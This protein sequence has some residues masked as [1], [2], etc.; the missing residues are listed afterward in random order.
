M[1]RRSFGPR[2]SIASRWFSIGLLLVTIGS[3]SACSVP[4]SPDPEPQPGPGPTPPSTRTAADLIE[5]TN[6]ERA[7]TG[8]PALAMNGRLMEAAQIQ[9]E[10]VAAAGR[11]EHTIADARLPSLE[12][13][14]AAAGYDWQYVGENLAFGQRNAAHAVDT[15][16][17]SPSHRS[18]IL[19]AL[20]TEVGAGYVVDPTGRPYYVQVF[21]KP[22]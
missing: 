12:D 17:Q 18:N 16:M 8:V 19:S 1:M 4:S 2:V 9:A 7:R 5:A 14:V 21:G 10:Q 3:A 13:R 6:A 11:L 22:R 15:W 20:F